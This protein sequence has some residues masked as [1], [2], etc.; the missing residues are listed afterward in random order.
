MVPISDA[1]PTRR[2]PIMN[3]LLIGINLI[4]FVYELSLSN[5]GLNRFVYQWGLLP[6]DL[7]AAIANPTAGTAL[8]PFLTLLTSQFIHGGWSHIL[9]NMLFLYIFGDNVEDVMGHFTY[10]IFYLI[11]GIIAGLTQT[12]VFAP[13]LG[14]VDVPSIGASGAIA[15]VLGAYLVLFPLA[16]VRTIILPLFF[17]PFSL[18]AFILIGV[19]FILQFVS[20]VGDLNATAAASGGVAYWAHVGGFIAGMILIIPFWIRARLAPR[21]QP[22]QRFYGPYDDRNPWYRQ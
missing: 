6:S 16:K 3:L 13:F 11:F 14:S 7:L 2:V 12:L 4:V 10:L 17:L 19:W 22:V 20:G 21:P 15:G 9:G 8:H 1:N 5:R 18:P